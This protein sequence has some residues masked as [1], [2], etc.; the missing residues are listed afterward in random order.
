MKQD[1]VKAKDRIEIKKN[2]GERERNDPQVIDPAFRKKEHRPRNLSFRSSS[3]I[4]L[5]YLNP[6]FL[7]LVDYVG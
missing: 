7:W 4:E 3:T 5:G 6:R 1:S 2:V